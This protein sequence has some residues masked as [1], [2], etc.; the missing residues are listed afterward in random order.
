VEKQD[1]FFISLFVSGKNISSKIKIFMI[2]G[3]ILIA[4]GV[5]MTIIGFATCEFD[6]GFGGIGIVAVGSLLNQF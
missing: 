6:V 4:T 5:A 1:A 2:I 3:Q